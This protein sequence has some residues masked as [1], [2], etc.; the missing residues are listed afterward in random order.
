MKIP[1]FVSSPSKL[2]PSQQKVR[3]SVFET[4]SS[5]GL[6]P[7]ALGQ[8]D[9]PTLLPLREVL[10]IA[11]RCA[12]ALILGF[13]QHFASSVEVRRG[14]PEC[15][16]GGCSEN[17]SYPTPWN[18]LEAGILFAIGLPQL[19]FCEKGVSGGI[20]DKGVSDAFIHQMPQLDVNGKLVQPV[21]EVFLKWQAEVRQHYYGER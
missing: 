5:Y 8:S 20:F 21:V 19:V 16:G 3:E 6:E 9:Y 14:L 17:V 11:K 12:G 4:L 1:V 2:N 7:R 18:H 15:D 13:E 10:V